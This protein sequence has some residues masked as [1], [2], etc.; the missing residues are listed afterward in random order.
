MYA[1]YG[2]V[3]FSQISICYDFHMYYVTAIFLISAILLQIFK[4]KVN[5][6]QIW[7]QE[8]LAFASICYV[9]GIN[10]FK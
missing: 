2:G 3:L 7:W 5:N 4:Q 1:A 10:I 8:I 6:N 9:L